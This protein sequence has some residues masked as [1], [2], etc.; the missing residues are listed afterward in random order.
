MKDLLRELEDTRV[1][2]EEILAQSKENEKKVKSMEA[3]MIQLQEV[4]VCVCLSSQSWS[5]CCSRLTSVWM[6]LQEL[7]AS[8]RAKRL[9]QQE[10]DELQ[11]EIN[12][13]AAKGWGNIHT[14][15]VHHYR[16]VSLEEMSSAVKILQKNPPFLL[17]I[18]ILIF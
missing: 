10:R 16:H 7:A 6:C 8:E 4:S 11:D 12:N 5:S 3:E 9:A 1:S 2:R 15:A 13:Q 17:R 18:L 14:S